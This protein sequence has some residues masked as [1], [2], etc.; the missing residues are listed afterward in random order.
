MRRVIQGVRRAT[1]L[2]AVGFV[3]ATAGPARALDTDIFTGTQVDPNVLIVFDNSGSMGLQAYNTYPNTIYTGSYTAGT[4]YSRCSNK[5][6]VSG[7]DVNSN[8]TCKN[9]QT[10][11]VVDNSACKN[12]FVDTVPPP[13]GDDTDDRESRR[14]RGN[15]LNFETNPPK[16]CELEPFDSCTSNSQCPG[17]GNSCAVQNKMAVAQGVVTSLINDPANDNVR[18]GLMNFNPSGINYG[19]M[20]YGSTSAITTWQETNQ[21]KFLFPV[22]DNTSSARASLTTLIGNMTANGGTPTV[23]RLI[24]AW[25]YFNGEVTKSGWTTS[26][27]QYTCQRNYVLMVTDGIPEVEADANVTP[28]SSCTFNRVKNFV[29]N[30]RRPELRRQGESGE[31][32]LPRDDGRDVQLRIGLPR[33]RDD[34]RFASCT[35]SATRRTSRWRCTRSRSASTTVSR[36]RSATPAR[37]RLAA[38]PCL[39]EVRRRRLPV[40][41]RPR[42][43]RRRAAR[44][45][46]PDQERRAV[47]RRAGG[48]GQP[49]QPYR[50]RR[51]PLRGPV[52]AARGAAGLARQHQ[53]VPPRPQQRHDLQCQRDDVHHRQRLGDA[54][55]RNHHGYRAVVL[56]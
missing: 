24:D 13:A 34:T 45:A 23:H 49:D 20:N 27:V 30:P 35:R 47:V 6:G 43:A 18:F 50:V 40:G 46:E 16:N 53:E 26:P 7:G 5:S 37:R 19:T 41:D 48:A 32:E 55:R 3:C 56:G 14:K 25:K 12:S 52:R 21:N 11:W 51:P 36:R 1:A 10:N 17:F 2:L 28:Q 15:R 44:G 31:L 4:I 8:C 33:R 39:E 38:L 22:Q 54:R 42:S 29:G 9:V